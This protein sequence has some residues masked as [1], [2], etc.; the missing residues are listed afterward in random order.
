[1]LQEAKVQT[2]IGYYAIIFISGKLKRNM[3]TIFPQINITSWYPIAVCTFADWSILSEILMKLGTRN[4]R[5]CLKTRKKLIFTAPSERYACKILISL[6]LFCGLLKIKITHVEPHWG[7][8]LWCHTN[9][10]TSNNKEKIMQVLCLCRISFFTVLNCI[11]MVLYVNGA[12][13]FVTIFIC[14]MYYFCHRY[15]QIS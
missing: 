4:F 11:T 14:M 1:M 9:L 6:H 3:L 15:I 2:A 5:S 10:R 12:T 8:C 7:C 13:H